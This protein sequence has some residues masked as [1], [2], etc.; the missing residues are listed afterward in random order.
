MIFYTLV[1]LGDEQKNSNYKG[2]NKNVYIDLAFKLNQSLNLGGHSLQILT[3]KRDRIIKYIDH[4][5][6]SKMRVN[7]IEDNFSLK[8]KKNV[9][10]KFAHAKLDCY[11]YFSQLKSENIIFLLDSDILL[12][13]NLP[14]WFYDIQSYKDNIYCYSITRHLVSGYGKEIVDNDLNYFLKD[15][16]TQWFGGE[17]IGTNSKNFKLIYEKSKEIFDNYLENIEKFNH[18]GDETILNA[19]IQLLNIHPIDIGPLN[20]IER[21]WS[22][23]CLF[24]QL[25]IDNID[26]VS[27]I[28][29]PSSKNFILKTPIINFLT[30]KIIIKLYLRFSYC[31][32]FLK[33]FLKKLLKN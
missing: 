25:P 22:A 12:I 17:I 20:I 31:L 5:Y 18:I 14:K 16:I 11:K 29:L 1:Y 13:N 15:P 23:P 28:H 3:N 26:N 7:Q 6:S 27:F 24:Y 21:K 33:V 30:L 19:A 10:F 2:S 8:I 32:N 4:K 9:R